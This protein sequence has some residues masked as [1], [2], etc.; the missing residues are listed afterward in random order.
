MTSSEHSANVLGALA[1][2]LHDRMSEA[3]STAAAG[4]PE[5]G[6]AA[7]SLLLHFMERPRV[8][9]LHQ[10][11]GL[12]PSGAVRMLDKLEA[13]GWVRRGPGD[14]ARSTSVR[15]TPAGRRAAARVA[16]ARGAVLSD[17][18]SVLSEEQRATLDE[19]VG[20][21]LVGLM[22]DPGASRWMC[23]LCDAGAC[24]HR[25][26]ACP[27]GAE[28]RRRWGAARTSTAAG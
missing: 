10:A 25:E 16:A 19:L 5:N 12:T 9:L 20:T 27:V 28:A 17:A 13:A 23:R 22:R 11:L 18:L 6:A 7:L 4:Q 8:G 2:V 1:L 24:G 14:D 15:L 3:V 26:G 21:V